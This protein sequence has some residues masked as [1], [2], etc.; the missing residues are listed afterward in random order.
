MGGTERIEIHQVKM[1]ATQKT[2]RQEPM[3]GLR[4]LSQQAALCQH[5]KVRA[6]QREP[7][8]ISV[9]RPETANLALQPV[10]QAAQTAACHQ[11]QHPRWPLSADGADQKHAQVAGGSSSRIEKTLAHMKRGRALASRLAGLLH[12]RSIR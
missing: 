11:I 10:A 5:A 6:Q 3:G 4:C 12:Q 2:I 8:W 7:M 9:I 1:L